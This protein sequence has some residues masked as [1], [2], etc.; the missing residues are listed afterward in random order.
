LATASLGAFR[1]QLPRGVA[2]A[3]LGPKGTR[4][5]RAAAAAALQLRVRR[6]HGGALLHCHWYW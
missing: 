4:P 1:C 3:G 6:G 2:R 5:A